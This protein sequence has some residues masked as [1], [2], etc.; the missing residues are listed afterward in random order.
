[1]FIYVIYLFVYLLPKL[2]R[3]EFLHSKGFIHRDI[4]PENF[5][6]SKDKKKKHVIYLI[7]YGMTKRFRD[8]EGKHIPYLDGKDFLG[9]AKFSSVYTHLGI[10]Q[11]RRDDLESIGYIIVYLA[12][13]KLPWL[14]LEASS[15]KQKYS[16]I[17]EIKKDLNFKEFCFGLPEQFI[18]YFKYIRGLQF[19]ETPD[20]SYIKGLISKAASSSNVKLDFNYDWE[21]KQSQ[22]SL[23]F[24]HTDFNDYFIDL[25]K[26]NKV[27]LK[28]EEDN[29]YIDNNNKNEVNSNNNNDNSLNTNDYLG[30]NNPS[31]S[32]GMLNN[33]IVNMNSDDQLKITCNSQCKNSCLKNENDNDD[34]KVKIKEEE[35]ASSFNKLKESNQKIEGCDNGVKLNEEMN[36]LN[37]QKKI[38]NF[39]NDEQKSNSNSTINT[40]ANNNSESIKIQ[41]CVNEKEISNNKVYVSNPV[42]KIIFGKN[43]FL[44]NNNHDHNHNK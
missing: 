16:I 26:S 31:P 4:K 18:E 33:A 15:K 34:V 43:K 11:S 23:I 36:I 40:N 25:M 12:T 2:Q 21:E 17:M 20:Y 19:D 22:S 41:N 35:V 7:D 14:G 44:N 27:N 24:K 10:E 9:T 6:I 30:K 38:I 32:C 42:N 39:S 29:I 3:I 1:M 5:L 37:N 28:E 8:K 13:G